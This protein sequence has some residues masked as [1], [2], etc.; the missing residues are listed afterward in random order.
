MPTAEPTTPGRRRRADDDRGL[1]TVEVLFVLPIV[2]LV[3]L[4][5]IQTAMWWYDRQVAATAA[6]EAA[7]YARYYT[8]TAADGQRRGYEYLHLVQG[9]GQSLRNVHVE[10]TRTATTVTVTVSGDTLGL[11]PWVHPHISETATGPVERY[12]PPETGP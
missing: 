6:Q 1:A 5:I 3:I 2:V 4:G 10:V 7:R 11:M 8:A 12:V 9:D